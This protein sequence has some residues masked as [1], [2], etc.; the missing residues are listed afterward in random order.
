MGGQQGE[1]CCIGGGSFSCASCECGC[2]TQLECAE[3][4]DCG[5]VGKVC[6][7]TQESCS[8]G[9]THFVSQCKLATS[10][11]GKRLCNPG[12]SVALACSGVG[13]MCSTDTSSVGIPA[14]T[15]YGICK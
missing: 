5:A 2:N 4:G 9:G 13:T 12:G 8:G 14:N 7:I 1:L 3:G 10:C 15:G 6:C 11:G